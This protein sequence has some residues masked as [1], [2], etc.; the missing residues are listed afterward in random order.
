MELETK[1][2]AFWQAYLDSL[3][4]PDDAAQRFYD[5]YRIGDSGESADTGAA[6]IIQGIKTTTSSLLWEYET[7][8]TLPPRVGSLSIVEDGKGNP[9]CV[10]ETTQIEI[11]PFSE[12]DTRFAYDYG[13]WDRTLPGWRK[14]CWDSYSD[15]CRSLGKEPTETMP[16]VCERFKVVYP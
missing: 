10:V 2:Q 13:E 11:K 7:A 5:V 15:H 9:I 1:T 16:L 3:S 6:L 8:N 12:V 14:H 4:N